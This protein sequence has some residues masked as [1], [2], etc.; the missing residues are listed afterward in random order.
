MS[1]MKLNIFNNDS[2]IISKNS[3]DSEYF[4][5]LAIPYI[6]LILVFVDPVWAWRWDN[7]IFSMSIINSAH[8]SV[9]PLVAEFFP[10]SIPFLFKFL[11]N[12]INIPIIHLFFGL[13]IKLV[14]VIFLYKVSFE[15]SKNRLASI[16]SLMIFLGFANFKL[17]YFNMPMGTSPFGELFIR[18][19]IGMPI[20]FSSR[21]I[22]FVFGLASLFYFLKN[23]YLLASLILVIG[24]YFHP[25]NILVFFLCITA[26]SLLQALFS[27]QLNKIVK[28]FLHYILPFS[29]GIIPYAILLSTMFDTVT[30]IG[31]I[32]YWENYVLKD[33]DGISD[34]ST[35]WHFKNGLHNYYTFSLATLVYWVLLKSEKPLSFQS[36]FS[37]FKSNDSVISYLL[38]A[39]WLY[40]IIGVLWELFFYKI[41]PDSLNDLMNMEFHRHTGFVPLIAVPIFSLILYRILINLYITNYK[42]EIF[43]KFFLIEHKYFQKQFVYIFGFV[44]IFVFAVFNVKSIDG[45]R[46]KLKY[47]DFSSRPPEFFLVKATKRPFRIWSKLSSTDEFIDISKFIRKNTLITDA[48]IT[49]PYIYGF[50]TFSSR[51]AFLS[52]KLDGNWSLWNRKFASVYLKRLS[53]LT[54]GLTHTNSD[55]LRER[56]LSLN[57][58][59]II[60]LSEKYK[61]YNYFL[62]EKYHDLEFQNIYSNKNYVLYKIH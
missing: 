62:T 15:V 37:H 46:N 2:E 13:L 61:G 11:L 41:F 32:D 56:Y 19:H 1:P 48:F 33:S 58:N 21:Q 36:V 40:M 52:T 26:A 18:T 20:Y 39:P 6:W 31:F 23:R 38:M 51:Q 34:A 45:I 59:E 35:I 30:P 49:P 9:D 7:F 5:K 4:A 60:Q 14:T 47:L 3:R 27:S 29:I 55:I 10:K 12:F 50:R 25:A 44:C 8:F 28:F 22:A 17:W 53:D 54:G 42:R 43:G 24:F 16:I 57:E